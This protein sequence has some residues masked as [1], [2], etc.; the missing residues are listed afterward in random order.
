MCIRVHWKSWCLEFVRWEKETFYGCIWAL[1]NF[2]NNYIAI[3]L[4]KKI[5]NEVKGTKINLVIYFCD[6]ISQN[7]QDN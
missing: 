5:T 6:K 2:P 4:P 1:E 7:S 3:K